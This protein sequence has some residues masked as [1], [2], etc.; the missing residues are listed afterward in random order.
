M[1]AR[2]DRVVEEARSCLRS[3][4]PGHL[5]AP[6]LQY[7][8]AHQQRDLASVLQSRCDGADR[9]R[10]RPIRPRQRVGR[11]PA[12]APGDVGSDDQ[13]RDLAGWAQ[14]GF[15]GTGSVSRGSQQ[16]WC[17][18]DPSRDGPGKSL[19][20]RARSR[21]LVLVVVA[22]VTAHDNDDRARRPTSIVEV[23]QPVREARS[24][25]EQRDRGLFRHPAVAIGGAGRDTLMQAE[26]WPYRAL[27]LEAGDEMD[28]G[29]SGIGE[30]G[31]DAAV[32]QRLHDTVG[33]VH[34]PPPRSR[35]P[36]P[37]DRA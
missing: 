10:G 21:V 2:K 4:P 24:E 25:M 22:G 37:N 19:D 20:I 6:L 18:D 26:D 32:H 1:D 35:P 33:A 12:F 17:P 28:L 36:G 27:F 9:R 7:L 15:D 31:L 8:S 11:L 29:R 5:E 3:D 30:A 16:A 14:G 34:L 13:S 23:G